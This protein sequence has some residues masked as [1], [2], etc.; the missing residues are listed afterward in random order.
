MY[1]NSVGHYFPEHTITNGYFHEKYGYAEKDIVEKS[2]IYE[3]R[4]A[5]VSENTNTMALDATEAALPSLTYD[6][7]EVNL[8]IGATYSPYD[9]V[10]T[11]AHTIQEKY[12]ITNAVCLQLS[13]AC[14]S[15]CNALEIAECYLVAGKADKAL[16]ITS[17][18][19]TAYGNED[20]PASGFLWGD[21]AAAIFVSKEAT[22]PS[23][24]KIVGIRTSGL[25]HVGKGIRGVFLRPNE[26]GIRMPFG[27]D[28][29]QNACIYMQKEAEAILEDHNIDL[30]QL[31]FL[32]PHQANLRIIDYIRKSMNLSKKQVVVNLDKLGNTG[33]AGAAIGLSQIYADFKKGDVAVI[34]VFGGGYSSGSVLL[35]KE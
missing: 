17:E 8:I 22:G 28:V 30:N 11:M 3:R 6:I 15:L 20:D 32:I 4:Q 26:G 12:S 29:F 27:R 23:D 25:G 33:C 2:G 1:I 14:S 9:T 16:I 34:T 21:G 13:A 19:N 18:H 5:Q 24:L 31:T 35:V 10:G 7:Q